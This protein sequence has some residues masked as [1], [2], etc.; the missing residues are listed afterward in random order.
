[1]KIKKFKVSK[2]SKVSKKQNNIK[3]GG[4]S[5]R[6]KPLPPQYVHNLSRTNQ[7]SPQPSTSQKISQS[8]TNQGN[9][10]LSTSQGNHQLSTSQGSP[11]PS[12][13]QGNHQPSTSQG[14]SQSRTNQ[15]SPQPSTSQF[16]KIKQPILSYDKINRENLLKYLE[17]CNQEYRERLQRFKIDF[18]NSTPKWYEDIYQ[19]DL[20]FRDFIRFARILLNIGK[21]LDKD[22]NVINKKDELNEMLNN[23]E[24]YL[25]YLKQEKKTDKIFYLDL[26]KTL[27]KT[28]EILNKINTLYGSTY[29]Q[30][31]YRNLERVKSNMKKVPGIL[32]DAS[33]ATYNSFAN[34][35]NYLTNNRPIYTDEMRINI[36]I[37]QYQGRMAAK[38][39]AATAKS[40]FRRSKK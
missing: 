27:N 35:G 29:S 4:M 33:V 24:N 9:H 12:T 19:Y 8:R 38:S 20:S 36:G 22:T 15:G 26:I 11:Q 25:N 3:G 10:Q 40:M 7:G 28:K 13:S 18:K 17:L 5:H 6:L 34:P 31:Y 1:M 23:F 2:T 37:G 39:K 16:M 14:R 32:Q 21:N 30:S